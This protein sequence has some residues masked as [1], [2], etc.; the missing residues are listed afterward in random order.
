MTTSTTSDLQPDGTADPDRGLGGPLWRPILVVLLVVAVVGGVGDQLTVLND[1][2]HALQQPWFKPPDWAFPIGWTL[3]YI[4]VGTSAVLAWQR[5]PSK[6]LRRGLLLAHLVG[7]IINIGW[8][9]VFFTLQRPDW[10]FA[11]GILL[12]ISVAVLTVVTARCDLRAGLL[13]IIY[14]AWV[15][16]AG[17]M[18]WQIA[19]LNGPFPMAT[20]G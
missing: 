19:A 5:A 14:M 11:E 13:M 8:S 2:Y 17:A 18:T 10:A 9:F 12:W 7:A 3:I 1:W 16:F 15:T 6:T 4:V 20:G